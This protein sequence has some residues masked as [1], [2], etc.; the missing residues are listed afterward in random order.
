M[1]ISGSRRSIA[2]VVATIAVVATLAIFSIMPHVDA[3]SVSE[4]R[5]GPAGISLQFEYFGGGSMKCV[6][7]GTSESTSIIM[8]ELAT[9][10]VDIIPIDG[11]WQIPS[12]GSEDVLF[13]DGPWFSTQT[14]NSTGLIS[15]V[16]A[17]GVPTFV[18]NGS[19]DAGDDLASGNLTVRSLI[20]S[21]D[22]EPPVVRGVKVSATG[23]PT[24][25]VEV[26]GQ[27]K[28]EGELRKAI[29]ATVNWVSNI[30]GRFYPS[31]NP[32]D[33]PYYWNL[34]LVHYYYSGDE[35]KPYG[36]VS[37]ENY[38]YDWIVD[39][40]EDVPQPQEQRLV[41]YRVQADPGWAV[42]GS[43]YRTSRVELV[44]I[45]G[46]YHLSDYSGPNN[47][48][49]TLVHFTTYQAFGR[50][51]LSPT[52]WKYTTYQREAYS[53]SN[54]GEG[55]AGW[56]YEFG[57]GDYYSGQHQCIEPGL[58]LNLRDGAVNFSGQCSVTWSRA[59]YLSWQDHQVRI[60]LG[61]EVL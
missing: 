59:D 3:R 61:G 16:V 10:D 48:G 52:Y 19:I 37:F 53:T 13:V 42:Y 32:F 18:V 35:F 6:V 51:Y 50:D 45:S 2:I 55:R 11:A 17:Q 60:D 25:L 7:L 9:M 54:S 14:G 34:T 31:T 23:G 15:A 57:P 26:G 29:D 24:L 56:V 12:L 22:N 40:G 43:D 49:E 46:R 27:A 30:D 8:D 20:S 36:R 44:S 1:F 58:E 39:A 38:Y 28:D 41:R 47:A 4:Q 5:E 21:T 33:Y